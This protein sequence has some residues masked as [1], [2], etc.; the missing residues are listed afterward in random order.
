MKLERIGL[1]KLYIYCQTF[2]IS[3]VRLPEGVFETM[4]YN[5]DTG[6]EL[7]SART[8]T[9]EEAQE[10]HGATVKW[11]NDFSYN[12]SIDKHIGKPNKGQFVRQIYFP[13]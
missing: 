5:P 8:A 3:T 12:G 10:K 4:V 13:T 1:H 6:K 11:W 2:M 7:D 9:R